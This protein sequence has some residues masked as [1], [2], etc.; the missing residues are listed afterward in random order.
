MNFARALR[1]PAA[2]TALLV[3][4]V[5]GCVARLWLAPLSSSLWV[6]EIV[7]T[8]VIHF[9]HSASFD[10]APQVPESLYYWLPRTSW[11][12]FG[13]AEWA[14]RLPSVLAMGAALFFVVRIAMRVIDRRAGWLAFF[15]CLTLSVLDFLAIDAR[16][17][18]FGL[19]VAS[20]GALF[21][22][23]WF[24]DLRWIDGIAF[25]VCAALLWRIHLLYWPFYLVYGGYALAR[26]ICRDTRLSVARVIA[27]FAVIVAA[28][29]PVV[30][31]A[32]GRL[33]GAETHAFMPLPKFRQ[34]YYMIHVNV[35]LICGGAA[36]LLH[37]YL[38]WK[39]SA[40]PVTV[41]AWVLIIGWWLA[42][43]VCLFIYSR[44]SG[45][46]IFIS[47]YVSLMYPGIALAATA[48][49]AQ[50]LP[51]RG[52]RYGAAAAGIIA[53]FLMGQWS[54]KSPAHTP[55][56][57]RAA[58]A[59]EKAIST[60]STPVLCASPFIEAQSPGFSPAYALPGFLFSNLTYYPIRGRL[61]LFPFSPSEQAEKYALS[62]LKNE[63]V[64]A[65]RFVLYGSNY[66]S[67][68]LMRYLAK[69]PELAG[70][71]I[72]STHFGSILIVTFDAGLQ[73]AIR[74]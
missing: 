14:L 37:A 61:R 62:L 1:N 25:A 33:H 20:A 59:M 70:W 73:Q 43:P 18:A 21:L 51:D 74:R 3:V 48:L 44:I 55:D 29:L 30:A 42:C 60:D 49:V 63:L 64:P 7:T 23:R 69:R 41:P 31:T 22:V 11:A 57:W 28:L 13:D 71:K 15:L 32:V 2:L 66:G 34:F 40:A 19:A 5:A 38:K 12:I 45:N 56:D 4:L 9:P 53:L 65:R 47:R 6:D 35:L 8:F 24:D 46:G 68:Y 39:P 50:F 72:D 10:I 36:W 26:L 16:P 17:Y 52:W 27:V 58:A 54:A 67:G